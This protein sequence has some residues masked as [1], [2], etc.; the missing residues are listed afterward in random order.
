MCDPTPE[1]NET[2][3]RGKRYYWQVVAKNCCGEVDGNDWSFATENTPPVADAGDDRLVE[4]AC[5]TEQGTKVTLDGKESYD[6]EG[7]TLTYTWTGPFIESPAYGPAPTVTLDNGCP[8]EHVITLVVNDGIDDS[9]PDDVAITVVDTTPPEFELSVTPSVLWPPD[10]KMVL[11]EPSWT[12][13]D[14]CD[15]VPEVSLVGVSM[16][17][18]DNTKGDG[19][20]DNDIQINDDGS[21]YLRAERSGTDVGRIY[22]ITYQ[23]VDDCGNMTLRSAAV[24][25]PHDFRFLAKIAS[26]WLWVGPTGSVPEDLNN[27]GAV[28][29]DDF[30]KFAENWKK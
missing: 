19:Q 12:V 11:I 8:G 16:D 28:N 25:V 2:L 24:G 18:G 21:I 4:C 26:R 22:T 10:H 20:T 7:N 3:N 13:S 15:G 23:A 5:N 9:E 6:P 27:D 29:F 30:A 17:E 1:P 14:K